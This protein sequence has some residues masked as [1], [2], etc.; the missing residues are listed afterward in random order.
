MSSEKLTPVMKQFRDVKEKHPDKI[1]LFRMGDFYE[2][3]FDDAKIAAKLLGITLTA[4]N[5]SDADAPALAGFPYHALDSYLDKL[6]KAGQKVVI[7]EQ[8]EDPKFA[9]GVVKRDIVEII[10]PGAILDEKFLSGSNNNFLGSVFI[11]IEKS[12]ENIVDH[13]H[14]MKNSKNTCGIA[15]LDLSTGDFLFTELPF[16]G[17]R[18]EL[19]R[20]K[21]K[22]ILVENAQARALVDDLSLDYEYSLSINENWHYDL[23]EANEVLKKHFQIHTLESIGAKNKKYATISAAAALAYIKELRKEELK[24][25]NSISYYSLD[26]YMVVDETTRRNLELFQSMR[27]VTR[28]GSLLDVLDETRTPM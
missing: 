10:T 5:K 28:Q 26:S 13:T 24:H 21:P 3:F 16:Q 19:L 22:E 25:I 12:E 11:S 6:V 9:K 27:N 15:L 2:T 23:N 18:D 4:R 14:F 8:M 1:I 7:V 17:L 20:Q